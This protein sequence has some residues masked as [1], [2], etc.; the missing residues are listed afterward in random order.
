LTELR[1]IW[2]AVRDGEISW[3]EAMAAK[4]GEV[5]D[6]AAKAKNSTV[7]AAVEKVKAKLAEQRK[8]KAPPVAT[9][10]PQNAEKPQSNE[11]D[12]GDDPDKY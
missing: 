5:L 11:V 8:G 2:V 6:E 7:D 3:S 9:S 4:T 10:A 12:R 1:G